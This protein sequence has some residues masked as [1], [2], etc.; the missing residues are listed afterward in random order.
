MWLF[1]AVYTN[2]YSDTDRKETIEFDGQFIS[3]DKE[4]YCYAMARAYE[5]VK[6][7]E[8]LSVLKFV[9]C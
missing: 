9:S 5:M 6:E 7:D 8:L 4:R 3:T 2:I 1:Q